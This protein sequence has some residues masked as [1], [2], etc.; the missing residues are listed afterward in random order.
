MKYYVGDKFLL[1]G[2]ECKVAFVNSY[3]QAYLAPENDGDF[4]GSYKTLKGLVFAVVDPKGKDKFGNKLV[5]VNKSNCG[6]V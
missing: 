6:A 3:G 5:T 4:Y 2:V 1:D